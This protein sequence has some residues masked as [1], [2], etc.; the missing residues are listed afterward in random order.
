[1][2]L[3]K[4]VLKVCVV[5]NVM[6]VKFHII[7]KIEVEYFISERTNIDDF[8]MSP[9]TQQ[10]GPHVRKFPYSWLTTSMKRCKYNLHNLL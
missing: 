9:H 5:T 7:K 10:S 6:R 3:L 2:R 1:M 4:N 8:L